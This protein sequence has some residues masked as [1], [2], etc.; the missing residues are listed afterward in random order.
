MLTSTQDE[1]LDAVTSALIDSGDVTFRA[2]HGVLPSEDEFAEATDDE[3]T[4]DS[5]G[6][7]PGYRFQLLHQSSGYVVEAGP[8]QFVAMLR[9][10]GATTQPE[11][12]TVFDLADVPEDE[13]GLVVPG[14]FFRW[15]IGYRTDAR[16]G[17]KMRGS[18]L[19]FVRL[20]TWS[21]RDVAAVTKRA[22]ELMNLFGPAQA[23]SEGHV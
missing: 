19:R 16:T 12:E 8:E 1:R 20:P 22:N 3:G 23:P 17:Q 13:R 6:L 14:A 10:K 7:E 15:S 2:R 5:V 4:S 9:D 21:E 18:F 11:E